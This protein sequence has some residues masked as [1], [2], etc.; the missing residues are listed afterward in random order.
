MRLNSIQNRGPFPNF[1]VNCLRTNSNLLTILRRRRPYRRPWWCWQGLIQDQ[2]SINVV[3]VRET[4]RANN[5][6]NGRQVFRSLGGYWWKVGGFRSRERPWGRHW[7]RGR[8]RTRR[9]DERW[10]VSCGNHVGS[11]GGSV[12]RRQVRHTRFKSRSNRTR[13]EYSSVF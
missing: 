1:A 3:R 10:R 5:A 12:K 8:E 2:L 4:V 9:S 13:T 6:V 7:P 11:A